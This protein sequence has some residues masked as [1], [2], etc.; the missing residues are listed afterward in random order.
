MND[1]YVSRKWLLDEYDKRHKGT[2]G[3]ARKMIEEA[4]AAD[5]RP[6]VEGQW[7]ELPRNTPNPFTGKCGVYVGCSNCHAPLPTDSF[8][9][10]ISESDS[11]FCYSCGAKMGGTDG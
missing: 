1:D 6:V 9:D 7:V 3:G 4:P 5:V 2:P 10:Y 11:R 8:L